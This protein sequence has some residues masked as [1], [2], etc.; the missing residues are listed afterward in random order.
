MFAV[1]PLNIVVLPGEE[2]ALHLFEPRYKQLY[3]D[4]KSGKEFAIVFTSKKE[5]A[6]FGTLVYIKKVI[7]EFPDDTVD[8]IVEGSQ[9]IKINQ[10]NQI[11]P[12]KLYS[13]VDAELVKHETTV[14][15]E[16]IEL[17]NLFLDKFGK[18]KSKGIPSIF[19]LANRIE[20]SQETK[21]ELIRQPDNAAMNRFLINQIR[22]DL[23][24]REQENLLNQKFH[25]N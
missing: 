5:M 15:S 3:A 2:V 11:Y 23:K 9:I 18:R 16:L 14:S 13:G 4:F 24:V 17:F 8:L 7:N 10:F 22:F 19:Q 20:M 1:F 25:L 6:D 12:Q 21:R